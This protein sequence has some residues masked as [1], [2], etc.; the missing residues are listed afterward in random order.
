MIWHLG[1]SEEMFWR[2][3]R[4]AF[5]IVVIIGGVCALGWGGL[6]FMLGRMK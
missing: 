3:A 2:G 6:Y 1:D 4:D 5:W